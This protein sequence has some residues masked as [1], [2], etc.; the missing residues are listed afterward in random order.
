MSRPLQLVAIAAAISTSPAIA[1]DPTIEILQAGIADVLPLGRHAGVE[2]LIDPGT[3]EPGTYLLE[4]ETRTPDGDTVARSRA[5]PLAGNPAR[6]WISGPVP[7]DPNQP[8]RVS[9]RDGED[10]TVLSSAAMSASDPRCV[11]MGEG[12]ALILVVGETGAGLEGYDTQAALS[13]GQQPAIDTLVRVIRPED[14]PDHPDALAAASTI[15]LTG[16][17][18]DIGGVKLDAI[19]TWVESGG[20]VIVSLPS[21]G[22]PWGIRGDR[23]AWPDVLDASGEGAAASLRS[24]AG[25]ISPDPLTPLDPGKLSITVFP[26]VRGPNSPWHTI[27]ASPAGQPLA[28]A[29]P[30]GHGRLTLL[31]LDVTSPA[32]TRYICDGDPT[33]PLPSPARLWNPI[34]GRADGPL[35]PRQTRLRNLAGGG[36]PD[37]TRAT[38]LLDTLIDGSIGQTVA[39]GGRVS[40]VLG[41]LVVWLLLGGPVL[42]WALGRLDRTALAWPV[43]GL[44]G[45]AGG[46]AAWAIAG[47][48]SLQS[49]DGKHL[50]IVDEVSHSPIQR[51]RSWVD[52][53]IPGTGRR[54]V[55]IDGIEAHPAHINT[56]ASHDQSQVGFMDTRLL[57]T[58]ADAA[59]QVPMQARATSQAFAIE[60]FGYP[61]SPDDGPWLRPASPIT[62]MKDREGSVSLTGQLQ[63]GLT[64]PLRD[65][66][67]LW[68][69]SRRP[70][71]DGADG[72]RSPVNAWAWSLTEDLQPGGVID[73]SSL[74]RPTP[75]HDVSD[76]IA[77]LSARQHR[78]FGSAMNSAYRHDGI[79]LLG[80]FHLMPPPP[81]HAM[82]AASAPEVHKVTRHFGAN[83]DLGP[84]FG[85]PMLLVTGFVEDSPLP[86]PVF[87][88]GV[89][90]DPPRG[91]T[92]LRWRTSLPDTDPRPG[93]MP[94]VR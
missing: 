56:W 9:L 11:S 69:E 40:L 93:P 34:L 59:N 16:S 23:G 94:K 18:D 79:E 13:S 39:A 77:S 90:I 4:W 44:L 31:G 68:V 88:D 24:L 38:P 49:I 26:E 47:G 63:S 20:H 48:M 74:G 70:S 12:A 76:H 64:S 87:V 22:D 71:K 53:R 19:R 55:G 33:G 35:T 8:M 28:I 43:F 52:L 46:T 75:D 66:T 73:L 78:S 6:V 86:M 91:E 14:L 89:A 15:L 81:R 45:A 41:W 17:P 84:S 2:V 5:V 50:T 42:W 51:M 83:L 27:A 29:K 37:R 21:V 65:V 92:M 62:T 60:R 54:D 10:L 82:D 61:N 32:L 58:A 72:D 57:R 30:L 85:S 3:I 80:L 36:L 1:A 67:I 7:R 25:T